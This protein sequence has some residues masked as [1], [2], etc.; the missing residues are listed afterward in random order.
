MQPQVLY[1]GAIDIHM[2]RGL[3]EG[4]LHVHV[5]SSGNVPKFAGKFFAERVVSGLLVAGDLNVDRS[6]R[7]E[8]QNL[9]DDVGGLKK[10]LH[11]RESL[12]RAWRA[13]R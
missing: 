2:Q 8:I 6:G 7:A 3:V 4:L 13:A 10:K 11:A 1:A 9:R 5:G 12:R